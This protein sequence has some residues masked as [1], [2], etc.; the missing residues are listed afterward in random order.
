MTGP[1]T[2]QDVE[3][4]LSAWMERS[5]RRGRRSRL[6]EETF[7][8]TM[9]A[10]QDGARPGTGS[11]PDGR[12]DARSSP[13]AVLARWSS[14]ASLLALVAGRRAR[15]RVAAARS[16]RRRRPARRRRSPSARPRARRRRVPPPIP[17]TPDAA[18]GV[19][20]RMALVAG[21]PVPLGPR[22][23][24][25]RPDRP[26]IQHGDRLRARSDRAADQYQGI[27]ANAAGVWA[28]NF[29]ARRAA[30]GSTR[31]R[32]RSARG[33]RQAWRRRA[34][35][36]RPTPS[37]SPTSTAARCSASTRPRTRSRT[38]HRRADR[39]QRTELARRAASGASGSTSRTTDTVVRINPV[40]DTIAGHDHG[41]RR[42]RPPCGGFAVGTDAVWVTSCS[43]RHS[44]ARIDPATNTVV[45]TIELG[46]YAYNPTLI[47][48]A[49][50]VSVDRGSADDG[51]LGPD[52][53]GD[54][55]D[56]PRPRARPGVRRRRRHRRG[57]RVRLGHRRLTTPCSACR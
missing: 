42:H 18:I 51:F 11:M 52:R 46:G 44:M 24:P 56:R 17:V 16:R 3:R 28:T 55:L 5:R 12:R 37:G 23:G 4:A 32:S 50:W 8:E 38:R 22:P 21:G 49:P 2:D 48:G 13:R 47:D 25:A 9:R 54:E 33:S 27:A 14:S 41:A 35:S 7:A 57:R 34:S 15:P 45:A 29:D 6:L 39:H 20:A 1:R 43:A 19:E 40:T 36:R 30:S 26:G 53:P 10:R 31:R